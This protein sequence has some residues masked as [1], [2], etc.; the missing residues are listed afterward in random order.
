MA[1]FGKSKKKKQAEKSAGQPKPT[2]LQIGDVSWVL[3]R[4]YITEKSTDLAADENTYVFVVD[5]RA[6]KPEIREAIKEAYDVVPADVR[7]VNLPAKR[8]RNR[9]GKDSYKRN[10]KKAY[11]SLQEG[12]SIT[13]F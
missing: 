3:K 1:L 9:R 7:T 8:V 6:G 5:K 12:D 11:V 4:P 13:L 10:L 2:G